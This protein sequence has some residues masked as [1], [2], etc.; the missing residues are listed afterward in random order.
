MRLK[1]CFSAIKESA[2][3]GANPTPLIT[4]RTPLFFIRRDWEGLSAITVHIYFVSLQD[5]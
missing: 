5:E 2:M 3:S 1:F 4:L